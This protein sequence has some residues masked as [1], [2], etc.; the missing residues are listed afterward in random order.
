MHELSLS[1]RPTSAAPRPLPPAPTTSCKHCGNP[2]ASDVEAQFCC[3]GCR[4]VYDL[5]N[6]AGLG[7]YYELRSRAILPP[8]LLD[9]SA[10]TDRNWLEPLQ[11]KLAAADGTVELPIKLQGMRCTACVW[12]IQ[13]LFTRYPGAHRIV[14][15]SA[16]GSARL[17]VEAHF[18]LARFVHE[19]ERYGYNAGDI[20]QSERGEDALLL[21]TGVCL[22]LSANA[23]MFSA[24]IYFGLEGGPI[25]ALLHRLNFACATLAV[26]VGAPVFFRSAWH[27]LKRRVL[28][29]D[30]PIATG[31]ALTYAAAVWSFAT[32]HE[33]AAYYDSL[34]IFTTLML[35]GR[36]LKERILQRNRRELLTNSG[37]EALLVRRVKDGALE[38]VPAFELLAGDRIL[39]P[40]GDL[41]PVTG[42]LDA[43]EAA[44]SLDWI[45]GESEPKAYV[46]G[47]AIPA[48]A[49]NAGSTALSLT[50]QRN[51]AG[52]LLCELLAQ[53]QLRE[54]SDRDDNHG[55]SVIYVAVVLATGAAAFAYWALHAGIA[56]GLEVATAIYVVTC[57]C[58]I[59]IAAPLAEELVL[60]GLRRAGL[61]V[62]TPSFLARACQV[63]KVV[64]D[65]TGTLTTGRLQLVNTEPLAALGRFERD[66]LFTM[67][68]ASGH[69][70]SA[71][72]LAA[73][74]PLTKLRLEA[75]S[76]QELAGKGLEAHTH[77]RSYRFG[78][79]SWALGASSAATDIVFCVDGQVLCQLQTREA[80]RADA[81]AQLAALEHAGYETGI[82]SG[83]EA[84][85]VTA[86]AREL[87]VPLER[88]QSQQSPQDKAAFIAAHDRHDL[89]MIGDGVND[90]LAV[91]Q[92]FASGTP[93]IDRAVM[94][95]RTDFYFVTAGIKPI[96]LALRAAHVLRRVLRRNRVF[97]VAYNIAV[98]SLAL[99]GL[100]K[101]WL[102]AVLMPLSS[103]AVLTT[104]SWSLSSR[105]SLWKF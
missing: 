2:L 48:G 28:H 101:P 54:Q 105:S 58:A 24:A 27:A 57:P 25:H 6:D 96:H 8:S 26:L 93:S 92:A 35:L 42:T 3:T 77:G 72:V 12:L 5:L 61:F 9:A 7:R 43:G 90:S 67:V 73:L 55:F 74:A 84:S 39:V 50:C 16:R 62:R 32:G 34:T 63:R 80:L 56:R 15:N 104:T 70:K 22:A 60:A 11:A 79:P 69:P 21:R 4:T 59:G 88:V 44:C 87:G 13:Q 20:G 95:S 53:Q 46:A 19:L 98:V 14:I 78:S 66:V 71:A 99:L 37:M 91:S 10:H 89:L 45:D 76:V 18:P 86:I 52:S 29:L 41:I 94:P 51:F 68:S 97:A 47:A 65:K 81:R 82:L 83:D 23:M 17:S 31:I 103:I 102:A 30:L 40:P 75:L 100:M 49:F 85:R 1:T 33:G 36:W 64:F 38:L